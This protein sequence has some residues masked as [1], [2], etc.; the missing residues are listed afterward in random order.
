M[1]PCQPK[2]I[3][4]TGSPRE[5]PAYAPTFNEPSQRLIN[6]ASLATTGNA[7]IIPTH[8]TIPRRVIN[9]IDAV[10]RAGLGLRLRIHHGKRGQD[11]VIA[12]HFKKIA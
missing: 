10:L 9:S 8:S 2:Q 12:I 1:R 4:L 7:L 6:S 3:F 11:D 5:P